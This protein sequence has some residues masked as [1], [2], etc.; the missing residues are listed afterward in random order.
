MLDNKGN[1]MNNV[2]VKGISL[3]DQIEFHK[4]RRTSLGLHIC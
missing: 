3:L 1:I 4:A 2:D